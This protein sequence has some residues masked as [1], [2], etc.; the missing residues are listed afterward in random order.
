MIQ[1]E[2]KRRIALVY[3]TEQ[4]DQEHLFGFV[5][6]PETSRDILRELGKIAANPELP[7]D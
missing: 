6:T 5:C 3:T 4:Q 1:P 7:F 2:P